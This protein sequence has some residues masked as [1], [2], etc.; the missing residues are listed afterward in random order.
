MPNETQI[1]CYFK[2]STLADLCKKGED[3]IINF[4]VSFP[5]S[6]SP[7]FKISAAVFKKGVKTGKVGGVIPLGDSG[8]S[9]GGGT[10][11]CPSP[12]H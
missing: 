10:T 7:E 4:N 8:G 5:P 6:K 12:C 2:S 11:G 3:I 9:G 1:E